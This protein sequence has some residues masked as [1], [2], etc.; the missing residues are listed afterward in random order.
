MRSAVRAVA[1][2]VLAVTIAVIGDAAIILAIIRF[3]GGP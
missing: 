2:G 3:G 1:T